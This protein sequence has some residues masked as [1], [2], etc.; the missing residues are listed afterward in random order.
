[1]PRTPQNLCEHANGMLNGGMTM[2]AVGTDNNCISAQTVHNH[3]C[4]GGLSAHNPYVGC[5]LA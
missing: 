5:V 4:E 1:M 3:L 2:N